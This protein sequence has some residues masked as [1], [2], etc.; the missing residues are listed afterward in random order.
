[1]TIL[2]TTTAM[3]LL[4]GVGLGLGALPAAAQVQGVFNSALCDTD[5]NGYISA[6]EA[7]ECADREYTTLLGDEE[8]LTPEWLTQEEPVEGLPPRR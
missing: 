5:N 3:A 1:M 8:S 4:A 2:K 6:G 7:R